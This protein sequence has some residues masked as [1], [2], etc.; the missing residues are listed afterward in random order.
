[1]AVPRNGMAL[2][3]WTG[4]VRRQDEKQG[5]SGCKILKIKANTAHNIAECF[6][7]FLCKLHRIFFLWDSTKKCNGLLRLYSDLN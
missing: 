6:F 4:G 5:R 2:T 3:E 1:M 7:V